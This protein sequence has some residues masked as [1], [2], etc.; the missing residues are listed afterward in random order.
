MQYKDE[1]TLHLIKIFAQT[2]KDKRI[3][4]VKKS[5]TLLSYEYGLDSGNFSRTENGKIDP[6]LTMLW[7]ISEALEIPLS[8]LIKSVETTIG[9]DF[10][11]TEN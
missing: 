4:T 3:N 8:E 9:K 2:L 5:Q 1:K 7:R 10:K 6:K 11:I